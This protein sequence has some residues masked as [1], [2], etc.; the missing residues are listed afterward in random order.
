MYKCSYTSIIVL[1]AGDTK[2]GQKRKKKKVPV[3]TDQVN[4][5]PIMCMWLLDGWEVPLEHVKD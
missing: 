4:H 2:K 1:A 3:L 5:K